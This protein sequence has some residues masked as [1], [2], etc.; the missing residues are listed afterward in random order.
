MQNIL[1]YF[2]LKMFRFV[3]LNI[4]RNY[5]FFLE[6]VLKNRVRIIY[7]CALYTGKYGKR[8]SSLKASSIFLKKSSIFM[9]SSASHARFVEI[10]VGEMMEVDADSVHS[11]MS[12]SLS[13]KAIGGRSIGGSL[14]VSAMLVWQCLMRSATLTSI[15]VISSNGLSWTVFIIP[16]L[17][18]WL[19]P[20]HA[21]N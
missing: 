19:Y 21:C 12:F 3:A 17:I 13:G 18:S 4:N 8:F 6:S 9:L 7:G 15:P 2:A 5:N 11:R 16:Y 20:A 10:T 1:L 14:L